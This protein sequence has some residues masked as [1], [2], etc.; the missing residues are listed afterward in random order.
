MSKPENRYVER[1]LNNLYTL[2]HTTDRRAAYAHLG[3]VLDNLK[4]LAEHMEKGGDLPD[5]NFNYHIEP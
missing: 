3:N 5:L 4:D 1:A 2:A